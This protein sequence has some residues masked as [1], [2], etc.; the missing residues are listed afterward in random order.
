MAII[1]AIVVVVSLVIILAVVPNITNIEVTPG[2]LK[3][4]AEPQG[5]V[6]TPDGQAI[7]RAKTPVTIL[8]FHA[9]P[10]RISAR[11][12]AVISWSVTG[13]E[14]SSIVITP[15][16]EDVAL[17]GSQEV[18]PDI[19]TTYRMVA[20]DMSGNIRRANL[21]V[22]VEETVPASTDGGNGQ[23]PLEQRPQLVSPAHGTVFNH[24]PRTTTLEWEP[25]HDA[26]SYVVEI[27]YCYSDQCTSYPLVTNLVDTSYTFDF[28][29]A[30]PGRWR[31]WAV[32]D[33]GEEGTKTNW[34]TFSYAK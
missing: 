8:T 12:S 32:Y 13:E 15:E 9:E 22:A 26:V 5:Q 2:T 27:Q 34:W 7:A 17:T 30:Q 11:E 3:V 16:L 25:V 23:P 4:H 20:S 29:G 28:V 6:K 24:F 31:V 1:G 21:R 14:V 33:G 10:S 19:T 18:S